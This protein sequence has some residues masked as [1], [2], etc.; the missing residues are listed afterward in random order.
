MLAGALRQGARP[1]VL[2]ATESW[3]PNLARATRLLHPLGTVVVADPDEP[4][5]PIA[6]E[7]FDLVSSRQPVRAFWSEI[8][9]VLRPGG[10]YSAQHAVEVGGVGHG[11]ARY[12]RPV[13]RWPTAAMPSVMARSP[14]LPK[15]RTSCAGVMVREAR[16]VLMP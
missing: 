9:R 16:Q 14:T 7:A 4:P 12:G 15:P 1:P 11:P 6:D 5:L 10:T 13:I 3:P 8:A 2:A